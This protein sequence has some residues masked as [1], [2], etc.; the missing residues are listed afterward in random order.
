MVYN[1]PPQRQMKDDIARIFV[2]KFVLEDKD[3]EKAVFDKYIKGKI[4]FQEAINHLD[5]IRPKRLKPT[6][7]F[8]G[9]S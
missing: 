5:D 6:S 8:S 9:Y 1:R 2:K 4:T 3:R 7:E